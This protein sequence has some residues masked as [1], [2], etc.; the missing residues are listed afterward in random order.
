MPD[1]KNQADP[2]TP[3][4]QVISQNPPADTM[5]EKGSAVEIVVSGG[6]AKVG[7]ARR[8]GPSVDDATNALTASGLQGEP[9]QRLVG[10]ACRRAT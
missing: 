7:G 6:P 10:R 1:V 5:V 2:T 8:R 3:V 4:G 9:E